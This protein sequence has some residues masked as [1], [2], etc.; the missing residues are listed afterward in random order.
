MNPKIE[1]R[2][3]K[4]K[5]D[6][7]VLEV[8]DSGEYVM[9]RHVEHFEYQLSKYMTGC[10]GKVH[11]IT[12]ANGTDALMIALMALDI[13]KGAEVIIPNYNYIAAA[14][15]CVI[16][17]YKPVFVDVYRDTYLIDVKDVQRSIT[18]RTKAVICTHLFGLGCGMTALNAVCKQNNLYL[19]EDTAQALGVEYAGH[20]LGQIGDI[21]T[22]S[23]YPTKTLGCYGD[24]GALFTRNEYLANRMRQIRNH[25]QNIKYRHDLIGFNS[26]L[27]AINAACLSVKI[28]YLDSWLKTRRD[29]AMYYDRKLTCKVKKPDVSRGHGF[30][31]YTIQVETRDALV[32]YMRQHGVQL[33]VHYPLTCNRN[34]AYFENK[35]TPNAEYLTTC[36]VSL[37]IHHYPDYDIIDN[38]IKLINEYYA[39]K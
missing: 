32:E 14:E 2:D 39:S 15:A 35:I 33:S 27:S 8:L 29:V 31:Q 3:L 5:I 10:A 20:K 22:T 18:D 24:G 36:S 38:T 25:G 30:H 7:A 34:L 12:C 21:G 4:S 16:L 37:P 28:D 17:G 26:R 19:I 11:A 9:G 13:P 1:Y 6:K 23:F